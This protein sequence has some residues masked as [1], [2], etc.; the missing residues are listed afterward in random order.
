LWFQEAHQR[1]LDA[2]H[3]Y[4]IVPDDVAMYKLIALS[5]V[6][7]HGKNAY[8]QSIDNFSARRNFVRGHSS[9]VFLKVPRVMPDMKIHL[10][11]VIEI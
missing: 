9:F 5:C 4:S 2:E 1:I 6:D 3:P 7:V 8:G 10:Q 11:H